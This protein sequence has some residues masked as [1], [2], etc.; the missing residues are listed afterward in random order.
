MPKPEKP[1]GKYDVT[2]EKA[3]LCSIL[4]IFIFLNWRIH[5]FQIDKLLG[6]PVIFTRVLLSLL[7]FTDKVCEL[8]CTETLGP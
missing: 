8:S 7:D 6:F 2:I 1:R 3:G 5:A 4:F